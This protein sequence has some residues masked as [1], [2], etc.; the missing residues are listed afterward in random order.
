M[1]RL[2]CGNGERLALDCH[3]HGVQLVFGIAARLAYLVRH[4]FNGILDHLDDV[5]ELDLVVV[6][7]LILFL[8]LFG[9]GG[10]L[11]GI[12]GVRHHAY[13]A[14][15]EDTSLVR[16]GGAGIGQHDINGEETAALC[17]L[18]ARIRGRRDSSLRICADRNVTA[19]SDHC[20]VGDGSNGI[21][22]YDGNG[23]GNRQCIAALR[24]G[25]R[26][27]LALGSD[28]NIPLRDDAAAHG[29]RDVRERH[30]DRD[31]NKEIP[32]LAVARVDLDLTRGLG[33]HVLARGDGTVDID[34]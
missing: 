7:R 30:A 33:A 3:S 2:F 23:D 10:G 19:G 15:R 29:G 17:F 25:G 9:G 31:G 32:D 34:Q 24:R 14:V 1:L 16:H 18:A 11:D 5:V 21:G 13:V 26:S 22:I 4:E 20:A 12:L 8:R 27:Q 28:R 6:C